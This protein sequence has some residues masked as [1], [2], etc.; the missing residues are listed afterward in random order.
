[1]EFVYSQT[2]LAMRAKTNELQHGII[3]LTVN[4][5][6]IR[7]DMTYMV[8]PAMQ[9]RNH[10]WQK[11]KLQSSIRHRVEAPLSGPRALMEYARIPVLISLAASAQPALV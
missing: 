6:Q 11:R 7:L 4:Q 1:M 9:E 3:R 5:D 2:K 8:R 10:V